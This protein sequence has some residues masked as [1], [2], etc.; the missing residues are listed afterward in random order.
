MDVIGLVFSL[1]SFL[2]WP[3]VI[4]AAILLLRRRRRIEDELRQSLAEQTEALRDLR[5][6]IRETELRLERLEQQGMAAAEAPVAPPAVTVV[7]E[8]LAPAAPAVPEAPVEALPEVVAAEAPVPSQAPPH[9]PPVAAPV[10]K[11]ISELKLRRHEFEQRFIENWT[12]IL[13]AVVVVAGVTFVGIYTALQLA[14]FY[15]FL[16]TLG[17]AGTLVAGSFALERRENWRKF[18]G[19]LRSAGAAIAL[20]ACAAA[21]GLPGLGLQWIDAPLPALGLLLAGIAAN[22]FL[23]WSGGLQVMATLHVLLSL[24]PLAIVPP[25]TTALAIASAVSLFGVVLAARGR[26]DRHLAFVLGA[27]LLFHAVWFARMGSALDDDVAR[28][29]AAGC[30]MLVFGAAAFVHYRRDDARSVEPSPLQVGV[31]LAAWLLLALVLFVY[32]PSSLVRGALLIVTGV[33]AY[34]LAQR[35]RTLQVPWLQRSD[36]LAAQAFVLLALLS[37][38]DLGM[39]TSLVMLFVLAETLGFRWLVP[40]EQDAMLDRVADALPVLAAALLAV[41]GLL[42]LG[43]PDEQ[44]TG[45]AAVLFAGSALAVLGQWVLRTPP[46]DSAPV[47]SARDLDQWFESPGALLGTLAGV[48][49]LAG[50][51]A[52]LDRPWFEAAALVAVGMLL[53]AWARLRRA[54]LQIGVTLALVGVHAMSWVR[55]LGDADSSAATLTTHI[56]P[57][58]ALA[59]LAIGIARRGWIRPLTIA[60]AGI[61]VGLAAYLYFDPV[62]SLIPGVAWLVL[63]LLALEL[64]NRLSGRESLVVLLLGYGYLAAFA[65]AYAVVIVQTPA[66]LGLLS[67]R[68][69]IEVFALAVFGYWWLFRPREALAAG[70]SW[71][72]AHPLFVELILV[73]VAVTVV[74]EM[75][76]QWWAVAWAVIAL[77]LLSPQAERLLDVRARVYSLVFY[78]VSVIDMA[79]VMSTLE[80]P[81]RQWFDQPEFTSLVAIV[82]QVAYVAWAHRRL[83]LESIDVPA[84]LGALGALGAAVA[85][86]RN[87]YV[88]YPM[89]AGIALF[90]YWRFDR[91]LLTLLWATEAFVVFGL[92]AWLR[93]NQFRYVALAGLAAC[94]VRLVFIDMAEANLA[95]RGLV[96]IG[97]GSLMLGMNAIYNRY[98][99]RFDE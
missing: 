86:R 62:S 2:F 22:L 79:V 75:A 16:L 48:L 99:A 23:A 18:G 76:A 42:D 71:I 57:L 80:V 32:V 43:L 1:I 74:V 90:L 12:G 69:L 84:P 92:S 67:A 63:S 17:V 83:Q 54:G 91:S 61:T 98:R 60:L 33:V 30:A 27:Y 41:A 5:H 95:L 81:S 93:E 34:R 8:A 46:E 96:F 53:A 39:S 31:H 3:V 68:L 13:G 89:F 10:E 82:L 70:R 64:A 11:A 45:L 66:Y 51:A 58:A 40:R 15:R 19:W 28:Y 77:V 20:F 36:T 29:L 88:Y 65:V 38:F 35:G 14:P 94:L 85:R 6:R 25:T 26:W 9:A 56:G 55:L 24:V 97:V 50:L 44:H 7:E 72:L 59:A 21:G 87:L 52:V 37:G 4:V 47:T 73:G 49:A 78:W